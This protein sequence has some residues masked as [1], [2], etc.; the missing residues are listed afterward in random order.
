[1][2]V[3]NGELVVVDLDMLLQLAVFVPV[4]NLDEVLR[5]TSR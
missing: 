2:N 1:M 3:G 5:R 4:F